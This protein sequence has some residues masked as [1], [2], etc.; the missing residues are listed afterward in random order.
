MKESNADMKETK[1]KRIS[2]NA[3]NHRIMRTERNKY[4]NSLKQGIEN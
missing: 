3:C 4:D 2:N 1:K